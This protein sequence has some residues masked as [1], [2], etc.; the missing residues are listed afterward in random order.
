MS[1]LEQLAEKEAEYAKLEQDRLAL[2]KLEEQLQERE[3]G[4]HCK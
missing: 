1:R 4:Y 3:R 2:R